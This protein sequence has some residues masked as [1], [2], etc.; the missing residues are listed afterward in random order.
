MQGL[1]KPT[2]QVEVFDE[3]GLLFAR[4]DFAWPRLEV[5]LEFDGK[6]KYERYLKPGETPGDA[7]FREKQ[8][9]DEV[10]AITGYGCGRLVWQDLNDA[11]A[12]AARF[13]TLLG[14]G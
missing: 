1:P 10:R 3:F 2:P 9:E 12:T 4:V 6:V 14:L 5:F 8:R 7:V 13:R 11:A